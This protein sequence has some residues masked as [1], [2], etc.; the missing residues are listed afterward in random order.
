MGVPTSPLCDRERD[1]NIA[2][3]Q[4]GF[5][6]FICSPYLKVLA[7]LLVAEWQ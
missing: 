4:M 7:L 3:S 2:Q 5:F 1:L 6:Q